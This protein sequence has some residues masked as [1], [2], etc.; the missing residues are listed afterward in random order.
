[1]LVKGPLGLHLDLRPDYNS[2][3]QLQAALRNALL[4]AIQREGLDAARQ[5]VRKAAPTIPSGGDTPEQLAET[6]VHVLPRAHEV[7][8]EVTVDRKTEPAHEQN[9]MEELVTILTSYG[10][11][12]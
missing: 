3:S 9:T 7:F 6:L 4:Q 1:M 10:G 2:R 12:S 5:I 11:R 8:K